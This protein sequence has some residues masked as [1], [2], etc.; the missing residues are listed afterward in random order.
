MLGWSVFLMLDLHLV[1]VLIWAFALNR[2]GLLKQASDAIYFCANCYTTLGM[3][4][5]D[6]E[7]HWRII[8]P[9]IGISGLFTFA[10]TTSALVNVVAANRRLLEQLEDERERE[11]RMRFALRK[12][13]WD[14]LKGERVFVESEIEKIKMKTAGVSFLQRLGI[15]KEE[16]VRVK[17]LRRAKAAEIEALRQKERLDEESPAPGVPPEKPDNKE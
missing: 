10:W 8:S 13:E 11:M 7:E 2:V 14:N 3:G 9:I 15:W 4:K 17:E 6:V 5:V 1:E 12:Q 16:M